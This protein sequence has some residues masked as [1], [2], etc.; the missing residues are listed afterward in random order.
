MHTHIDSSKVFLSF[1][2]TYD[3]SDFLKIYVIIAGKLKFPSISACFYH[4]IACFK[5]II[6]MLDYYV[7]SLFWI[8]IITIGLLC[9]I[10][11]MYHYVGLT[12]CKITILLPWHGRKF[13]FETWFKIYCAGCCLENVSQHRTAVKPNLVSDRISQNCK[14]SVAGRTGK[15]W[16][17]CALFLWVWDQK[18]IRQVSKPKPVSHK[19][20]SIAYNFR[21]K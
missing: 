6:S 2:S 18:L 14:L 11:I 10:I 16:T 4:R 12:C 20:T 1:A 13:F 21:Q 3:I 17:H 19:T 8:I 7:V 9:C 5:T 15:K